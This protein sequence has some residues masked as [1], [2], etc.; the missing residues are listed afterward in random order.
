MYV[1]LRGNIH[2]VWDVEGDFEGSVGLSSPDGRRLILTRDT[3]SSKHV[4]HR[5]LLRA[6]VRSQESEARRKH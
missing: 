1:D 5:E 4:D 3:F 2:V 6:E